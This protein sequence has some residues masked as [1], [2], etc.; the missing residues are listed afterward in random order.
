MWGDIIIT[1]NFKD[2]WSMP[3]PT[4]SVRVPQHILDAIVQRCEETGKDKS[5]VTVEL[6]ALA[7]GLEVQ[8]NL[9]DRL[10]ALEERVARLEE[11]QG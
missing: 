11:R 2:D 7:L 10:A 3:S 9:A 4:L 6:L 1:H 8:P 5:E